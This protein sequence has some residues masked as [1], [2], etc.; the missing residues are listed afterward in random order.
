[1]NVKSIA[2]LLVCENV[3]AAS[4]SVA[5]LFLIVLSP[6]KTLE[7]FHK[8]GWTTEEVEEVQRL[9]I[10]RWNESYRPVSLTA[11]LASISAGVAAPL[12]VP[13]TMSSHRVHFLNVQVIMP[14]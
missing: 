1:M 8:R 13:T 3:T 6:D 10:T 9:V 7:W 12:V 4:V 5:Y 2:L 11:A 14:V